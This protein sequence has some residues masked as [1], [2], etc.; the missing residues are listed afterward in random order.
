MAYVTSFI[1]QLFYIG[2][3]RVWRVNGME[4][5]V[6][7]YQRSPEPDLNLKCCKRLKALTIARSTI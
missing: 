4:R 2:G 1:L 5:I 7:V 3:K 6:R